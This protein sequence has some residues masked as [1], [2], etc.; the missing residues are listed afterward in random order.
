M[1][2]DDEMLTL[3]GQ[4]LRLRP[5]RGI[6]RDANL[7]ELSIDEVV[8]TPSACRHFLEQSPEEKAPHYLRAW[9]S[10]PAS[11]GP[12]ALEPRRAI[13][14][15]TLTEYLNDLKE[16]VKPV[17]AADLLAKKIRAEFPKYHVTR[18]VVRDVHKIV[19]GE[20]PPGKR[21]KQA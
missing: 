9:F 14:I 15:Q 20:L 3:H 4:P 13:P 5:I 17:P 18:N 21:A 8:W 11:D 12:P 2:T 10:T 1:L 16:K 19:F 7:P 6:D